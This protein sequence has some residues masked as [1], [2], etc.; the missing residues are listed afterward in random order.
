MPS[1]R[2]PPLPDGEEDEKVDVG[3]S[4]RL[5]D[6]FE[7]GELAGHLETDVGEDDDVGEVDDSVE[8][9]KLVS[10]ESKGYTTK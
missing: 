7:Q 8:E 9:V 4:V 10:L 2:L 5:S 3:E 6:N 1:F